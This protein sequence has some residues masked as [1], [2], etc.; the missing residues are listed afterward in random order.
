M[1]SFNP[2]ASPTLAKQLWLGTSLNEGTNCCRCNTICGTSY[3]HSVWCAADADDREVSALPENHSWGTRCGVKASQSGVVGI[4]PVTRLSYFVEFRGGGYQAARLA[5]EAN[6][7]QTPIDA[8]G[9]P[10]LHYPRN[11]SSLELKD[12]CLTTVTRRAVCSWKE[13]SEVLPTKSVWCFPVVVDFSPASESE[14]PRRSRKKLAQKSQ[15]IRESS[16]A[17]AGKG[18]PVRRVG[19]S[20]I[21]RRERVIK[22]RPGCVIFCWGRVL[23]AV[24][25]MTP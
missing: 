16:S 13:T 23:L 2:A 18:S 10:L 9:R 20:L 8:S 22:G 1:L 7:L 6:V 17:G 14:E 11:T 15:Q 5:R 3:Y 25:Y 4:Q 21:W 19:V 24:V 12:F